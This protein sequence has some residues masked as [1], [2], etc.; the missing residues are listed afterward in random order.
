LNFLTPQSEHH[1]GYIRELW[2]EYW[3]WLQF[4][5]C[6]QDFEEELKTLPGVYRPPE[7][8]LLLALNDGRPVGCV[9]LRPIDGKTCEMK[10]LYVRVEYRGKHIGYELIKR[11]LQ[12]GRDLGYI[13]MRLDTLPT[14][15]K[16]VALYEHFGF[17]EIEPYTKER[18]PSAKYFEVDLREEEQ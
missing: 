7:G 12:A 15:E 6:F 17:K 5:P 9:G 10:R 16:A 2:L 11:S 3:D 8:W 4:A 13:R 1:L 14:M 18:V